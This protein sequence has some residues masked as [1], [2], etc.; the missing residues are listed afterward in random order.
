MKKKL[1]FIWF[2]NVNFFYYSQVEDTEF[3]NELLELQDR[4]RLLIQ[5]QFNGS[6]QFQKAM[7]DAFEVFVNRVCIFK[8]LILI[9]KIFKK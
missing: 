5:D 3:V 8:F 1:P 9:I 7:K 6:S 4:Y 2:S